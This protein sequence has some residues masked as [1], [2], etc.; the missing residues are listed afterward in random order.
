MYDFPKVGPEQERLSLFTGE[1]DSQVRFYFDSSLPPMEKIGRYTAKL[2][3][4]GYF[5]HREFEVQL[6]G[7][8]NFAKLAFHGRGLTG[9]DPFAG[10]Y[11]GVWA[12]S[13]SPAV[14]RTEGAFDSSG[15]I[16]K[17]TSV[18][19]GPSGEELRLSMVTEAPSPDRLVF[20][21]W[22]LLETGEEVLITEM[23]HARRR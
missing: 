21:I 16:F 9:Y 14:Y 12:D 10:K 23:T 5:L 11:L 19:P 2:D 22:R 4:G 6:D 18:G 17:E 15:T 20:K 1:W 13:G 3:L 7:A 8:G